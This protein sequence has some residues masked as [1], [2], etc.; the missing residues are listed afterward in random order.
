[1]NTF[2]ALGTADPFRKAVCI[3]LTA[4]DILVLSLYT[5]QSSKSESEQMQVM[6]MMQVMQAMLLRW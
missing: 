4:K 2:A 6:Q 5:Q 1:L 3:D